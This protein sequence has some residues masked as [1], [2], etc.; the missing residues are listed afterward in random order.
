VRA[1]VLRHIGDE[2]L[3]VVDDVRLADTRPG[4]VRVAVKATGVCH[5]DLSAMAGAFGI[6]IPCVMGHEGTGE[7]IEVGEG[8]TGLAV[9]DHVIASGVTQCGKCSFCL[10]GQG[11][12][13][14]TAVFS[15]PFFRI[16]DQEVFALAGIGSFSEEILLAQEA[17][18]VIDPAVPWDVAALLG[19]GVTTGIGAVLNAAKLR[20]GSSAIVFGCGGVGISVIQGA[21]LAGAAEIV[22]VDVVA[23][24]REQ[25]LRYGA[26]RAIAPEE[27][28][29]VKVSLTG[30]AGGFDYGFEAVGQP[31]TIRAAYDAVR[32]GGTAVIIGV[33]HRDQSVAFDAYEL[34]YGDKTIRGTWFG[35][36]DPRVEFL[37][38]LHLWK[39]GR[40]DLEG[41]ITRRGRLEDI[42]TAFADLRAGAVTRTVLSV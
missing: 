14:V 24:Q 27:V 15:A 32:R 9:G 38:V 3:D 1:A 23:A 25:A 40:L 12:L 29:D 33:G 18:I 31:S 34:A 39:T 22:A 2:A 10:S 5:S 41:M 11:H 30:S 20:P 7:I 42:N 17:A 21:R 26:T 28:E 36:G 6:P 16:G 13:C 35:S 37:R 4:L 19:C 8:V